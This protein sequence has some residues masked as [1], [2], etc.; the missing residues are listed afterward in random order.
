MPLVGSNAP[1]IQAEAYFKGEF[2]NFN[3]EDYKGKWVYLLFYPLDFTFVCPTEI[4]AFSK[5]A[6]E[7]RGLNCEVVGV[8]VDSKFTHMAW[9]D[10]DRKDGGLGGV[11]IPLVSD[12]DKSISEAYGVLAGPV[13]LRGLFLIDPEGTIQHTI[14]N[15]L[16]VGRSTAEAKRI[17]KAFQYVAAHDGE[18]CPADWDEG[19]STMAANTEGMHQFLGKL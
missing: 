7:L 3:L 19:A 1:A 8:S 15:N 2:T 12:L 18:V 5:A 4:L 11:D 9:A 6:E 14:I 16:S 17:L 10:T 13:A